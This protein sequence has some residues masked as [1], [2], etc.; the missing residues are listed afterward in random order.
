MRDFQAGVEYWHLD[1]F[2]RETL[3][4]CEGTVLDWWTVPPVGG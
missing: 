3:I 4:D 2:R 1:Q